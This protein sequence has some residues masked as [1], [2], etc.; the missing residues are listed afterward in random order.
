M[1][2]IEIFIFSVRMVQWGCFALLLSVTHAFCFVN[3]FEFCNL[4]YKSIYIYIYIGLHVFLSFIWPA[5]IWRRMYVYSWMLY[6]Y[7]LGLLQCVECSH[8]T[9]CHSMCG[10]FAF[11]CVIPLWVFM[12]YTDT[13]LFPMNDTKSLEFEGSE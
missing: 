6:K 12:G 11:Y 1:P 7:D 2:V 10:V 5:I 13:P 8:S 9:V 4:L 3:C